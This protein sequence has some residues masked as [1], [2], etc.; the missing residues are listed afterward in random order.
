MMQDRVGEE[1]GVRA[2]EMAVAEPVLFAGEETLRLHQV[3][4]LSRPRHGNVQQASLLF[5]LGGAAAGHVGR[6]AAVDHVEDEDDIP[7]L[8]FSRMDG[9]ESQ[10]VFVQ[11]RDAGFVPGGAG[12]VE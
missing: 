5:D 4:V 11:M 12:W 8:P 6:N 1:T 3:Q 10:V 7:L 2:V 9:G